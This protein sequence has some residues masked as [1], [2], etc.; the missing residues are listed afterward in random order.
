MFNYIF[1]KGYQEQINEKN[2]INKI[3]LKFDLK[4]ERRYKNY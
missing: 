4:I 1:F 2:K 3:L